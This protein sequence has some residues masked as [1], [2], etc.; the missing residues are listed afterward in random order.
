[1]PVDEASGCPVIA[2]EEVDGGVEEEHGDRVVEQPQD[3]DGVNAVRRA[4]H[5]QQTVRWNLSKTRRNEW[6]AVC[7]L[8]V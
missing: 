3:V 8:G 4:A 7:L 5:E 2:E 6:R 1:M